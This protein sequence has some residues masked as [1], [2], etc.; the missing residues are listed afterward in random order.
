MALP[1]VRESLARLGPDQLQ[2]IENRIRTHADLQGAITDGLGLVQ[3]YRT[4]GTTLINERAALD[5][6]EKLKV[7]PERKLKTIELIE[8]QA[9]RGKTAQAQT[10]ATVFEQGRAIYEKFGSLTPE[11]PTAAATLATVQTSLLN[12][13]NQ[14]TGLWESLRDRAR[15]DARRDANDP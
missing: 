2:A 10:N 6:A 5:E 14:A 8:S 3:K 12:P 7:G 15:L 4:S 13:A 1:G 11:D 9:S